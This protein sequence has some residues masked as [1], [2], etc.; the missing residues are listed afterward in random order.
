MYV[1]PTEPRRFSNLEQSEEV[2]DVTVHS[3]IGDKAHQMQGRLPA[4]DRH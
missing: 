4:L 3:S 2:L 1:H